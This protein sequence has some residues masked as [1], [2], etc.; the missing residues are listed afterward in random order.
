M[1]GSVIADGERSWTFTSTA[2]PLGATFVDST[3][4]RVMFVAPS[5]NAD[6]Q[7]EQDA[8]EGIA[9]PLN[10]G[11]F[12]GPEL[13][14]TTADGSEWTVQV[15]WSLKGESLPAAITAANGRAFTAPRGVITLPAG[16]D[17]IAFTADG[18]YTVEVTVTDN[19]GQ[20][21]SK[22]FEVNV[23]K[24]TP[25]AAIRQIVDGGVTDPVTAAYEGVAIALRGV[26]AKTGVPDA[27]FTTLAWQVTK[28]QGSATAAVYT[29]GAG[30][31]FSF[32]PD[33]AGIYEVS[34]SAVDE[35]GTAANAM[36]V[37]FAVD[38]V[39]PRVVISGLPA[40]SIPEGTAIS[41]TADAVFGGAADRI[42]TTGG[43]AWSVTRNGSLYLPNEST[44]ASA[45]Q[46][47][48]FAFVPT[49]DGDYVVTVTVRD[50][51]GLTTTVSTGTVKVINAQPV[52]I[53]ETLPG[54][55]VNSV[56]EGAPVTLSIRDAANGLIVS[57]VTGDA[58]SYKWTV[59]RRQAGALVALPL[60]GTPDTG[61]T[62]TFTPPD[63]GDYVVTLTVN[64]GDGGTASLAGEFTATN[65][66]PTATLTHNRGT[67]SLVTLTQGEDVIFTLVGSDAGVADQATL[68]RWFALG[69]GEFVAASQ[70]GKFT[71]AAFTATGDYTVR[72]K[73][74]DKDG[75]EI[76][77]TTTVSVAN[78]AP[79]VNPLEKMAESPVG[80]G[81][82]IQGS[83]WPATLQTG[84]LAGLGQE[85]L[86]FVGTGN[87]SPVTVS[88][89]TGAIVLTGSFSD[90]GSANE[91]YRGSATIQRV[92]PT[93]VGAPVVVPLMIRDNKT[94]ELRY[95]FPSGGTY[96]VTA[97]I[98]DSQGAASQP[99]TINVEVV[100]ILISKNTIA[101][102][103]GTSALVGQLSVSVA[104]PSALYS[105]VTGAGDT[106]NGLFQVV[107]G[108][109]EARSS[110]DVEDGRMYSVRVRA[111]GTKLGTLDR[112]FTIK[113]NEA[114]TAVSLT[115]TLRAITEAANTS[116]RIRVADISVADD[117]V[118]TNTATLAGADA[119]HFEIDGS[120]LYLKAGTVLDAQSKPFYAVAV[121]VADTSLPGSPTA[122]ATYTLMTGIVTA[123]GETVT[124]SVVHSGGYE[125]VKLG[126]GTLVLDKANSHTGGVTVEAGT[127][128]IRNGAA[129]GTGIVRVK[130]GAAI[131]ID[132]A[133]GHVIGGRLVVEPGGR[134]DIGTGRLTISTGMTVPRILDLLTTARGSGA[135]TSS[136]GL[137]SSAVAAAMSQGLPRTLGWRANEDGSFTVAYAAPGDTNLD[138]VVDVLDVANYLSS[139]NYGTDKFSTWMDGD[140]NYDGL[141]DVIDVASI[142]ATGLF[143]SGDYQSEAVA[144][145]ASLPLADA[146]AAEAAGTSAA[147][148]ASPFEL[149]FA[150]MASGEQT[151]TTVK[152]RIFASFR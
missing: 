146:L 130:A 119:A 73:V 19:D 91:T 125:L 7:A 151:T 85:P 43:F 110:L 34:F 142:L 74:T 77:G 36:K 152:K 128:V 86:P 11:S 131:V 65:V 118:G 75:G 27:R 112:V 104:D 113:V 98:Y 61:E 81:T 102:N 60:G 17:P 41:L 50:D 145:T 8:I 14:G 68:G 120:A 78:V 64:D 133:A 51:D 124:D 103:A 122:T 35:N 24:G 139:G 18:I 3:A 117:G 47:Q 6:P 138:N 62:F 39:K 121:V 46:G 23:G 22:R 12:T 80:T 76:T 20:K 2:S 49:D 126:T 13:D 100:E 40:N 94:F 52:F 137:G 149:A 1:P 72:W 123:A 150:A 54:L 70:D 26:T 44:P 96:A 129:L 88:T 140:A 25:T 115:N 116:S 107:N 148:T 101:S 48:A 79:T 55:P 135:W 108:R 56:P 31:D 10:L 71:P 9:T 57:D 127:I 89:T 28:Q 69:D 99:Q 109:L 21:E 114:P 58:L 92:S 132:P 97:T 30:S 32:T 4:V 134:V 136:A 29:S 45:T 105:L 66:A 82:V 141:L 84:S 38:D 33:D 67:G 63:N 87:A 147:A 42:A 83:A 93:P 144:S 53:T 111:T 37:V 95:T 143:D 5:F 15:R 106:D 59:A 16:I 90:P